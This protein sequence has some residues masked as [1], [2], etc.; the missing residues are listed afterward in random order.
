MP[1]SKKKRGKQK[2]AAACYHGSSQEA[3]QGGAYQRALDELLARLEV[4]LKKV[5]AKR[6]NDS[7][8]RMEQCFNDVYDVGNFSNDY[9]VLCADEAF[10]AYLFAWSANKFLSDYR[11]AQTALLLGLQ[12]RYVIAPRARAEATE[13]GT[14]LFRKYQKKALKAFSPRGLVLCVAEQIPCACLDQHASLASANTEQPVACC[15]ACHKEFPRD[16]LMTCSRC[17]ISR[18]CSSECQANDW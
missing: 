6:V 4:A 7:N 9:P 16:N 18:Y 11:A 14:R 10:A 13:P 8:I 2:R 3:F 15:S 12:I 5:K 17:R 1:S